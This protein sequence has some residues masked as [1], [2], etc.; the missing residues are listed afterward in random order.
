MEALV[1]KLVVL[2]TSQQEGDNHCMYF[3]H[4]DKNWNDVYENHPADGLDHQSV[5]VVSQVTSVNKSHD[6]HSQPFLS[7]LK[8]TELINELFTSPNNPGFSQANSVFGC[9]DVDNMD[10]DG[11]ITDVKTVARPF[12]RQRRLGS[13]MMMGNASPY[14]SEMCFLRYDFLNICLMSI[15][16]GVL[17]FASGVEKVYFPVNEKDFHWCLAELHIRSG[18]ITFYDSLGGPSNG[19]KDRLFWLELRQI[20]ELSHNLPLEVDD[21]IEF[22]LAYRERLIEFFWKHKMLV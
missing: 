11:C 3:E 4:L 5:E 18:V 10:K 15:K 20:F 9:V 19:I 16:Y 1:F 13:Q 22:S 17:W 14:M 8:V 7:P 6:I 21:S 12:L 2:T